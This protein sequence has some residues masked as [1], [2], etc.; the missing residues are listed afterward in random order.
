MQEEIPIFPDSIELG[1][2]LM[3]HGEELEYE[4]KLMEDAYYDEQYFRDQEMWY[5]DMLIKE[6]R[7]GRD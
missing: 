3:T 5:R 1:L 7:D 2:K 6:E 4:N